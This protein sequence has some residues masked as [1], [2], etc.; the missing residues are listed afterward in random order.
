MEQAHSI[1]EHCEPS[2]A[3]H[4]FIKWQWDFPRLVPKHN[5]SLKYTIFISMVLGV[6]Y[7]K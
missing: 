7:K 3:S 4:H 5:S 6:V 1:K 2:K